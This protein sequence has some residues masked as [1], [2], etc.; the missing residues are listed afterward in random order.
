MTGSGSSVGKDGGMD[1]LLLPGQAR[2]A[3]DILKALSHETRLV[4]LWLLSEHERSVSE[5]ETLLALPQAAVSQQLARLRL[6]RLVTTRRE[7]RVIRY[8]LIDPVMSALV[9]RL[10]E[11]LCRTEP[12]DGSLQGNHPH[13]R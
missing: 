4:I 6:D 1:V 7:G 2:M 11:L 3:S 9:V 8:S 13:V 12:T 5:L 10:C